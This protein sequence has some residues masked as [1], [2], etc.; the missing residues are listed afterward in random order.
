MTLP[1]TRN[2]QCSE[3]KVL[4]TIAVSQDLAVFAGHFPGNP[5]LPGVVQVEWAWNYAQQFFEI[6]ES[7][8]PGDVQVKFKRP[9]IPDRDVLLSLLY[10]V[11]KKRVSFTYSD[12]DAMFSQGTLKIQDES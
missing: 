5:L 4:I 10:D 2:I 11:G 6:Q 3:N 9:I 7:A 12:H 1:K 8:Y